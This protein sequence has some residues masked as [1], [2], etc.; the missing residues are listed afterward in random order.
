MQEIGVN[1]MFNIGK[2]FRNRF[3]YTPKKPKNNDLFTLWISDKDELPEL[4]Q[5]SI[6]SMFLTGHNVTLYSYNNLNN[7]P[8]GIINIDANEVLDHSKIFK[9]K[10]G[11]NKG[12]YSGFSNWFRVKHLYEKGST[13]FDCDILAIK[14]INDINSNDS[15]ISSQN[16]PDGSKGPV[17]S[18]LRL[19]KG[20]KLLKDLLA[21]MENIKDD[22]VH[23]DT[24]PI[25]FKS[26]IE[27]QHPEYQK[28]ITDPDFIASINFFDY[29]DFLK[30]SAEILPY[31][32]LDEIWGF[33][34]WNAMFRH[35]GVELEGVN[36]GFYHDLK[37]AILSSSTKKEYENQL[38]NLL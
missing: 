33:H 9:Y 24:G 31:L 28:C 17:P 4:Q 26:M 32:K 3:H 1:N 18:F 5:L 10:S 12:S 13:W 21:Y 14:N 23:G 34:I 38:V 35:Y 16:Y 22:V 29:Q 30:P 20:D 25:L 2:K 36:T 7:I 8:E 37:D 6:K 19:K 27:E 11:F 15:I